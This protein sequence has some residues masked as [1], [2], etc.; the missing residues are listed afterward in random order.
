MMR[1]AERFPDF[2]IVVTLSQQL[3]WSHIVALIPLKS[4]DEFM[5]YAQSAAESGLGVRDLRQQIARK[6][7]GYGRRRLYT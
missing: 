1:F 7:Y 3:S 4:D 6:A 2:Q 5:Y